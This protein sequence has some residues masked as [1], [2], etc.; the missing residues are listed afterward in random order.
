[1][2][3]LLKKTACDLILTKHGSHMCIVAFHSNLALLKSGS[4][5]LLICFLL[6]SDANEP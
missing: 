4:V 3:L 1:M 2:L 6:P 5:G